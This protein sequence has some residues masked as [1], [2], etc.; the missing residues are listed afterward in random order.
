M[1]SIQTLD[2]P[3][4]LSN[5]NPIEYFQL[6]LKRKILKLYLELKQI[7]QSKKDLKCLIKAYKEVQM[8]FN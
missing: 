8:A 3:P 7:G 1:S 4:Y 5:L 2:F 6:A